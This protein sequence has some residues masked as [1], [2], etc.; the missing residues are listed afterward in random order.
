MH[1]N[2]NKV[3]KREGRKDFITPYWRDYR[4]PDRYQRFED[5]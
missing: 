4:I 1:G 5:R 3:N 2:A